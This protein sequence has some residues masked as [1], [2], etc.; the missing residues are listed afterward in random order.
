MKELLVKT[1]NRNALDSTLQQLGGL[2]A[3]LPEPDGTYAVRAFPPERITFLK[4]AI[5]Q[6]GYAQIVGERD[7]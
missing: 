7:I 4:F 1:G 6:Q 2:V 5:E 3:E